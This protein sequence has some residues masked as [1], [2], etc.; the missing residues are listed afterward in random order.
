MESARID[1][2]RPIGRGRRSCAHAARASLAALFALAVLAGCSLVSFKSPERPLSDRDMNARLLTRELTAQLL[3]SSARS[4]DNILARETDPAV[5]EHTLRWEL[6]VIET[7]RQAELQLAPLMGLVDTWTLALQLQAFMREGAPGGKL[8]GTHQAALREIT[9]NYADGAVSLARSLL[10]PKEF[11]DYQSFVTGYVQAHPLAD[12]RFTRPSVLTEW[13]REK[14]AQTNLLDAV[15]TIPQALADTSQ[16]LE[17]YG[18]TVPQQ[19]VRRTQLMMRESGYEPSDLRAALA[20]LD[21]RLERL[22]S[23]AESSPELVHEAQAELR[24]SLREVFDRLDASARATAAALH[25]EREALF[26]NIHTERE[27]L[28]AAVDAQRKSLTADAG[29]ITD[30]LVRTSGQEVRR[31]TRQAL[32]LVIVLTLVLLGLPFAAGYLVGRARSPLRHS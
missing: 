21:E 25:T 20:R 8:F 24:A 2:A 5:L 14:G 7:S 15:G 26:E 30:Q 18:D 19:A 31:F 1:P 32:L 13:T 22:T 16:R 28:L 17:I 27:A 10:T 29:R 11:T 6:G 23:V 3:E 9:D 4:T 12:L